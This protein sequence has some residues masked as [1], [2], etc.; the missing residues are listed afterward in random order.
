MLDV[1][2]RCSDWALMKAK[3]NKCA[4]VALTGQTGR[5]HD[6]KLAMA[7]EPLPS[8]ADKAV[9]FLV[10]PTTTRFDS[11]ETKSSLMSN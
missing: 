11:E 3:V 8:L 1:A 5:V 7:G 4:A 6:P 2:Q 9:K 10:L